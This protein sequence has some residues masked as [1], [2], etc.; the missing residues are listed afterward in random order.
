MNQPAM[1]AAVPI[2]IRVDVDEAKRQA[3]C[4]HDRIHRSS[5]RA[6]GICD[7][8]ADQAFEVLMSGADMIGNGHDSVTV[9]N[10]DET[11]L[12]SEPETHETSIADDDPLKTI[13]L[14]D[15]ERSHARLRNGLPP[16]RRSLP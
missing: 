6:I 12:I 9:M 5:C 16:T 14:L 4:S 8:T 15:T 13:E 11:A 1:K 10:P 7:E 2:D 3:S